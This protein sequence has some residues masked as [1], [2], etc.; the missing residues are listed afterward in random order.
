[1]GAEKVVASSRLKMS[2]APEPTEMPADPVNAS[3]PLVPEPMMS[4][5]WLTDRVAES[6][7]VPVRIQVPEPD[8][9]SESFAGAVVM[10]PSGLVME[11]TTSASEMFP[12]KML[13]PEEVVAPSVRRGLAERIV[14]GLPPLPKMRFPV[15]VSGPV[16]LDSRM[17]SGKR[18]SRRMVWAELAAGPV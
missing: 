12:A 9:M 7:L 2:S 14:L 11:V 5:P 17:P 18:P 15:Q 8:L 1:M 10:V 4:L 16:P 6:E 13:F 3:E